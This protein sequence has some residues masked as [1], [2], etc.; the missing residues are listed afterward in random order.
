[1][2]DKVSN[3]EK[4]GESKRPESSFRV[5]NNF[6]RNNQLSELGFEGEPWTWCNKWD[7]AG[8]VKERLDRILIDSGW[9]ETYERAK[10]THIHVEAS[11]HCMMLLEIE[12]IRRN[13]KRRFYFD[14]KW[15]EY[16]EVREVIKKAWGNKQ[17]G[18]RF[19]RLQNRIKECRFELMRW[20]KKLKGNAKKDIEEVKQKIID[21]RNV[22]GPNTKEEISYLQKKLANAYKKE[23]VFWGRKARVK[24]LQEGDKNTSY[25]HAV[26]EAKRR[27]NKI[28]TL[29]KQN[30]N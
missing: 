16:K 25:F 29:Q 14:R 10:C 18:S 30:E 4:W 1:M 19:F 26:V 24:R 28:S 8:E 22:G 20:N 3:A 11:D 15:L 17:E 12:P 27:R 6:I 21:I 9:K 2:K 5:F 7:N 13:W 23:E